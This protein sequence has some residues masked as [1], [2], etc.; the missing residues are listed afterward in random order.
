MYTGRS[1]DFPMASDQLTAAQHDPYQE[2]EKYL[3]KVAV[4]LICL[5]LFYKYI[6]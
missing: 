2:M 4:S 3:E 5:H 1:T 6:M